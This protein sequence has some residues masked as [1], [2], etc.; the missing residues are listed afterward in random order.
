MVQR[1]L[2]LWGFWVL[3][4]TAS[5]QSSL[6]QWVDRYCLD[7]HDSQSS[8][9][10]LD[11]ESMLAS[12]FGQHVDQ[13]EQVVGKLQ[14]RQMPPLGKPRPDETG[15]RSILEGLIHQLDTQALRDPQPGRTETFRRLTRT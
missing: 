9:G 3:A 10:E 6:S 4:I 1:Y 2:Q 12:E 15:Y 7:C 14:A 8:K 13:W 5:A 11:L